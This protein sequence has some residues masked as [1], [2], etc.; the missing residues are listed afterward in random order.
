[1]GG[2]YIHPEKI[3][4]FEKVK[5]LCPF[6]AIEVSPDGTI[7]INSGCRVCKVCVKNGEP[8]AFEYRED[9]ISATDKSEWQGIA[10][11]G[12]FLPSGEYHP[13][14]F[15]LL[16]K[17]RELADKVGFRVSLVL[18]GNEI[19][20]VPDRL[21][22]QGADQVFVYDA[23]LLKFF[24]ARLYADVVEDFALKQKPSVILVGG[25]PAGRSLAP[26]IAAR[27][28]T[29][30]TADCTELDIQPNSDLD[31]IRPAFGGNIMAHIRTP[32]H[33]PQLATVRYKIFSPV[34]P[35]DSRNGEWTYCDL[36]EGLFA[37]MKHIA[38]NEKQKVQNIEDSDILIVAGRGFKKKEDLILAR[39]LADELGGELACTRPLIEAGWLEPRRQVGLSGRTVKPRLLIA[40]GVS[41]SVQFAAGMKSSEMI[42]S[43][44]NDPHAAINQIANYSFIGDL[45]QII[46]AL[47][48]F[49]KNGREK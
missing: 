5:N 48:N 1:M 2:I 43:I 4:D 39:Q 18:I 17:A 15:E 7:Q 11:L 12:E 19:P 45:Y 26:R 20:A 28:H 32:Y 38:S 6:G 44:N 14:V 24:D 27:L 21:W 41:G 25:T 3:S 30:L 36:P 42:L 46:P 49:I 13:V 8:G 40:C 34:Q 10:V 22:S 29:G 9:V 33:R 23:P 16:G 31:Q 35:D 47:L 37:S